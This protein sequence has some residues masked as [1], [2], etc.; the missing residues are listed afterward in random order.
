M[1]ICPLCGLSGLDQ[2][3]LTK[4]AYELWKRD[5]LEK[6]KKCI[7]R[8]KL[9]WYQADSITVRGEEILVIGIP[10][11]PIVILKRRDNPK[12]IK[13]TRIKQLGVGERAITPVSDSSFQMRI[14]T[15]KGSYV[16]RF[17]SY[18]QDQF[19]KVRTKMKRLLPVFTGPLRIERDLDR[20]NACASDCFVNF[21]GLCAEKGAVCRCDCVCTDSDCNGDC[22]PD[23]QCVGG[24]CFDCPGFGLF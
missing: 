3:F 24:N 11:K 6:H 1:S 5:V 15:D 16:L 13:I 23:C 19:E 18:E 17:E 14:V 21:R 2:V 4:E 9:S 22:R 7:E 10:G 20:K 8:I 12:F